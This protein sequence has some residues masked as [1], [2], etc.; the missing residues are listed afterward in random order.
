MVESGLRMMRCAAHCTIFRIF[1]K[2]T[3]IVRGDEY[4]YILR[5][6]FTA[7]IS[8]MCWRLGGKPI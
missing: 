6:I 1:E 7:S 3:C 4:D 8:Q 5:A 2:N